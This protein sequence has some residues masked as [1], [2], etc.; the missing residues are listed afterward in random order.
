GIAYP[1]KGRKAW[2][3]G[4]GECSLLFTNEPSASHPSRSY[5]PATSAPVATRRP[6]LSGKVDR[7]PEFPVDDIHHRHQAFRSASV[8]RLLQGDLD[9]ILPN[10]SFFHQ[11]PQHNAGLCVIKPFPVNRSKQVQ[12]LLHNNPGVLA[13]LD[14]L[15]AGTT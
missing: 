13:G 6:C 7:S 12:G 5:T 2:N 14:E 11:L 1:F 3:W 8:Y 15:L 4:C 10:T 9:K